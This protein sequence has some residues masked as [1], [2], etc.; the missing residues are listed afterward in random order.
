MI[1]VSPL[2]YIIGII[3]VLLCAIVLY[4][5]LS[6]AYRVP[7]YWI[8]VLIF[9]CVP[10]FNLGCGIGAFLFMLCIQSRIAEHTRFK[11][12]RW[13]FKSRRKEVSDKSN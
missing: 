8:T 7:L 5:C 6:K 11:I 12:V 4:S 9:A 3:L 1:I 13:V 2:S 10:A